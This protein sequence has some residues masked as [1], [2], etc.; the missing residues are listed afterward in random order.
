M[1]K[2]NKFIQS[3]GI[4]LG[5]KLVQE[6]MF[7]GF[8]RSNMR[9]AIEDFMQNNPD[10]RK[11]FYCE[12]CEGKMKFVTIEDKRVLQCSKCKKEIEEQ[13]QVKYRLNNFKKLKFMLYKT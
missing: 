10:Y 7:M 1:K 12:H 11:Y 5:D 8:K 9:V 4:A 3:L 13:S 6:V 2:L